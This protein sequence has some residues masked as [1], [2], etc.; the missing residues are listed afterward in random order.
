MV[1]GR[2]S[3]IEPEAPKPPGLNRKLSY[4][5]IKNEFGP[6]AA[7]KTLN[8][9]PCKWDI[10]VLGMTIVMGGQSLGWNGGLLNDPTHFI[11]AY[12]LVGSGYI[13][14]CCCISELSGS[15]PFAGGAYG[16]ARCTLGFF[17]AFL[18]GCFEAAVYIILAASAIIYTGGLLVV[19][20]PS[21]ASYELLIYAILYFVSLAINI[22]GDTLFWGSNAF[23]GS[24]SLLI[25][26]VYCFGAIPF[27]DF[28]KNHQTNAL[29]KTKG[30]AGF[31]QVLPYA[32]RFFMGIESVDLACER[33]LQPKLWIPFG[34]MTGMMTLFVT[35]ASILL[36]ALSLPIA[37]N[38][39]ATDIAPLNLCFMHLLNTSYNSATLLSLPAAFASAF[40]FIWAYGKI[41]S[42]MSF[43]HLLPPIF[44]KCAY[45]TGTP[46]G[47]ALCGSV[48]GYMLCMIS[49]FA[50]G[51]IDV[52]NGL[53]L[54]LAFTSYIGQ[55]V[56]YFSL[57]VNYPNLTGSNFRSPF[58]IV[59]A[60]YALC[61]WVL[62]F[63]A[64]AGFQ[65]H[66]TRGIGIY[67]AVIAIVAAIYHGYSKKR[68]TFSAAENRI[69]LVAHVTKFN[70]KRARSNHTKTRALI[71]SS[72][73][74][75]SKYTVT[76]HDTVV[77][78][79]T[80][81]SVVKESKIFLSSD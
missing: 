47:A 24:L 73:K 19:L 44:A 75:E 3:S 28:E 25:V 78:N 57:K 56:G 18:I 33:V 59:G 31:L 11:I 80:L 12:F 58:G 2:S 30:F 32:T 52:I 77:G 39:L 48:L 9:K 70:V 17:P 72:N 36:V 35:G 40:G 51:S 5:S 10:W 4:T 60:L 22:T 15:L 13:M 55:C 20:A 69:M 8:Y 29:H 76:T 42:G 64:V 71:K 67:C 50:S 54:M 16:I 1:S 43:S 45:R 37:T 6:A 61:V 66:N 65:S 26:L 53:C 63:I 68:Q 21:L 38:P 62:C 14:L 34:Q 46:A 7:Q 23:L 74:P 81:K 27:A 41:L 49:F 79:S